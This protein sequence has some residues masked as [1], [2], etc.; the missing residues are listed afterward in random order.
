MS[1][2]RRDVLLG[3]GLGAVGLGLAKPALAQDQPTV[4]WKLTSSFVP[5]LDLIYGGG[6]TVGGDRRNHRRPVHDQGL[7]GRRD[8]SALE[9]LDAVSNGAADCAHTAL[10]YDWSKDP[11]FIFASSRPSA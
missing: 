6:A 8:R 5:T 1:S 7:A 11:S 4:T 10:S 3:L 2:P 9:T